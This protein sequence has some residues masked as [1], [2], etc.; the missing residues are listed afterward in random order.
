MRWLFN[1]KFL[2]DN[3]GFRLYTAVLQGGTDAISAFACYSSQKHFKRRLVE[4]EAFIE[5]DPANTMFK[6]PLILCLYGHIM[7]AARS[8]GP[9]IGTNCPFLFQVL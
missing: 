8:Y 7:L 1:C 9:A 4:F 5:K 2:Q 6:T 3:E